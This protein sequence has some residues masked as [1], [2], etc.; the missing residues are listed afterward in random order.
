MLPRDLAG[1]DARPDDGA[2]RERLEGAKLAGCAHV[3]K[4]RERGN[5]LLV[6]QGAEYVP[7]A[8]VDADQEDL[9]PGLF[10]GTRAGP[11][12]EAEGDAHDQAD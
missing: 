7:F 1:G 8:G 2:L 9:G 12:T 6:E 10:A 4:L 3:A 5:P 11:C